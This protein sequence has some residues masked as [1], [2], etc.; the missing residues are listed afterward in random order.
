MVHRKSAPQA[1]CPCPQASRKGGTITT[2]GLEIGRLTLRRLTGA[3]AGDWASRAGAKRLLLSHF[4]PGS[5]RSAFVA[6][7]REQFT[8]EV[9]AAD[10]SM[11]VGLI[12][13]GSPT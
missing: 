9:P 3:D 13:G 12:S 1:T 4:W 2:T 7:A 11:V 6:E 5:D 8:G 10:E